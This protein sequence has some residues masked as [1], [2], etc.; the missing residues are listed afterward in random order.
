MEASAI[1]NL[2]TNLS[3]SR[4]QQTAELATLKKA[5]DLQAEGALQLLQ[6]I[7]PLPTVSSSGGVAGQIINVKA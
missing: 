5:I 7:P 3:N 4:V 2:A 6:A 1:A